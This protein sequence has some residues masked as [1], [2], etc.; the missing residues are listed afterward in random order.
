MP[1]PSGRNTKNKGKGLRTGYNRF[2]THKNNIRSLGD[3]NIDFILDNKIT[4]Q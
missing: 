2:F 4:Y 1:G 3:L